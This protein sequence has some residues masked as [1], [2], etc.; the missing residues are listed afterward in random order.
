[1]GI[2]GSLSSLGLEEELWAL[3]S[4]GARLWGW[5][6]VLLGRSCSVLG[7]LALVASTLG[8]DSSWLGSWS[9]F[10]HKVSCWNWASILLLEVLESSG[11]LRNSLLWQRIDYLKNRLNIIKVT[12]KPRNNSK[13]CQKAHSSISYSSMRILKYNL[14]QLVFDTLKYLDKLTGIYRPIVFRYEVLLDYNLNS[15]DDQLL[16]SV[17][18]VGH[19]DLVNQ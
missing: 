10:L 2:N 3:V 19:W 18:L 13:S 12:V 9:L 17:V 11:N 8:T 7:L 15:I 1:M 14:F 6:L 4:G 5:G 16:H